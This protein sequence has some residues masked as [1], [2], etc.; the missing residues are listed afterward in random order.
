MWQ[1]HHH[2]REIN[3]HAKMKTKTKYENQPFNSFEYIIIS[4]N[5]IIDV[6]VPYSIREKQKFDLTHF[7]EGEYWI[8]IDFWICDGWFVLNTVL[9]TILHIYIGNSTL[10]A[11]IWLS[12]HFY[13]FVLFLFFS[14]RRAR[15]RSMD[16]SIGN[17]IIQ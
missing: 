5:T 13:I 17:N 8:S 14:I 6:L 15:Q 1:Q 11:F 3:A 4:S 2:Q 16:R 10:L 12:V 7:E 9:N